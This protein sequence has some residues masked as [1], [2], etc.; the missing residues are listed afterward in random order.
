MEPGLYISDIN[1]EAGFRHFK[2]FKDKRTIPGLHQLI[3]L[4]NKYEIGHFFRAQINKIK[5]DDLKDS[6]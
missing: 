2:W 5:H 1:I 3:F 4:S 6:C